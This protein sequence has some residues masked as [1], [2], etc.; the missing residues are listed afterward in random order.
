MT[1]AGLHAEIGVRRGSL[2]LEAS[3][4][5]APGELVVVVEIGRAHV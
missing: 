2:I 4:E 3:I 1:S 5:V